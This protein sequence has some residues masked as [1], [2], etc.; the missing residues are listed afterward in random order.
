[1]RAPV[2][3]R[4]G[5]GVRDVS[6]RT[7]SLAP[8]V[9]WYLLFFLIPLFWMVRVSFASLQNFHLHYVWSTEAYRQLF[10]DP[11][12]GELLKRSVLLAFGVTVI[13]FVIGFPAAWI[14]SR[15]PSRRR[16]L[17]LV[18]MII[19]W[20]SS[21]IV[22]VFAWQMSFG[23]QGI[24]N[25]FLIWTGITDAPT[26]L[27]EFGWFGVVLA[28]VNLYLPLMIIPL[29]MSLERLDPDL[30]RA[31]ASLG[32]GPVRVV[33]KIVLPLA[34]PGIIAGVIFVFMPMTGEFIAPNLVGG[35]GQLL[36][37]N[38]IQSQFGVTYNW[39]YGSALAI[40]LLAMLIAFLIGVRVIGGYAMR[41]LRQA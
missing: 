23:H 26:H 2:R 1:M 8:A 20:W 4:R 18:L 16:N 41:N 19:P 34:T 12:V 32:A 17:I 11:L 22:R 38:Q 24:I 6:T 9:G 30:I 25:E 33:R 27:F 28:E 3:A 21:Y 10:D 31:A 7:A 14:L 37:G 36:Y 40:V 39:P 35:P 5:W 29:Y 13:T 15:Q